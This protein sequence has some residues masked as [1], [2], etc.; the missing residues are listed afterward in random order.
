MANNEVMIFSISSTLSKDNWAGLTAIPSS[1]IVSTHNRIKGGHTWLKPR[2]ISGETTEIGALG[3][4]VGTIVASRKYCI[5]PGV[6][7]LCT[8]CRQNTT[9]RRGA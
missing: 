6:N 2:K 7:A 3:G 8:L 9:A 4:S 1:K 5:L